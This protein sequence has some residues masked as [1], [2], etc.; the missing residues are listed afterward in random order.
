MA[1]RGHIKEDGN[2]WHGFTKFRPKPDGW[3]GYLCPLKKTICN[4][5][6]PDGKEC[7]HWRPG[8][9]FT[10]PNPRPDYCVEARKAFDN[11]KP[12]A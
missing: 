12:W 6:M 3:E 5:G 4:R 7:N 11:E 2:A 8:N 9:P 1:K 10:V